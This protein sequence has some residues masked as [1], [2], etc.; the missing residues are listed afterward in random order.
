MRPF[1]S[2][3]DQDPVDPVESRGGPR[4]KIQSVDPGEGGGGG[5][6]GGGGEGHDPRSSGSRGPGERAKIQ[7]PVDPWAPGREPRSKIQWIQGSPRGESQDPL[8]S[9]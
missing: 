1:W 9:D 4:S 8:V 2:G 5:G 7:D 6:G 3:E